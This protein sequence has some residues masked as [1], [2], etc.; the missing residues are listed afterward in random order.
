MSLGASAVFLVDGAGKIVWREQ[1]SQ[2]HL[3]SKGQMTEQVRRLLAGEELI[4]NGP[5]P[6]AAVDED[7]DMVMGGG[8]L[9]FTFI[10]FGVA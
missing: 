7:E 8:M 3:V 5:R 10:L 9:L 4:K 6:V 1:F 2:G